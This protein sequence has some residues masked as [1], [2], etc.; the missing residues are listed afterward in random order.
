MSGFS[1]IRKHVV[2][3]AYG[4]SAEAVF[5]MRLGQEVTAFLNL[6]HGKSLDSLLA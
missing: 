5:V 4:G 6:A 2:E 3:A 1:N